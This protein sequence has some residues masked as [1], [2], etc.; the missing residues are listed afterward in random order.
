MICQNCGENEANIK[1]TQIIN[2]VKKEMA[3]CDQCSKKLGIGFEMEDFHFKMPINLSSFLGEFL[4]DSME[5]TFPSLQKIEEPTCKEC[6]MT[7][8][9]FIHTGKFGCEN[10]YETFSERISPILK[11]IQGAN[12]HVGRKLKWEQGTPIHHKKIEP[13]KIK[14][15]EKNQLEEL[16]IEL[17]KAI[18]EERYEDAANI[19][20]NIKKLEK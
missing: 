19:R 7:Y 10:C 20:D 13:V 18:R 2:G 8:E 9:E 15:E 6:G 4:E 14:K 17:K 1:Y 5:E 3:I 11:N 12:H 16:Q